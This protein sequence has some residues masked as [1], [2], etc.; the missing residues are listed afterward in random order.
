MNNFP[1][2]IEITE[3]HGLEH[4]AEEGVDY[5]RYMLITS[6]DKLPSGVAFKIIATSVLV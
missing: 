5:F 1:I 6:P 3:P 4:G 2:V